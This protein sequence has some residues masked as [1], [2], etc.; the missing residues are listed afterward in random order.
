[1]KLETKFQFYSVLGAEFEGQVDYNKK[2]KMNTKVCLSSEC[3][4][5]KRAPESLVW[6]WCPSVIHK[7]EGL[8]ESSLG[9]HYSYLG[10]W[11][12]NSQWGETGNKTGVLAI[13]V[14]QRAQEP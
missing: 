4:K 1:M 13:S 10:V 11:D 3:L 7:L 2:N 8:V 5:Q 12:S 6:V 9:C 14:H